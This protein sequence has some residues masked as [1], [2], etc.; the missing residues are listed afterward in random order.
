MGG[1]KKTGMVLILIG[2]LLPAVLAAFVSEY[3]P[4]MGLMWNIRNMEAV[5]YDKLTER[6]INIDGF[7]EKYP[8]YSDLS[9]EEAAGRLHK[10]FFAAM[11]LDE[12]R[13]IFLGPASPETL[14]PVINGGESGDVLGIRGDFE[15]FDSMSLL[16]QAVVSMDASRHG[17]YDITRKKIAV[18]YRY[19]L[20]PGAFLIS[21]GMLAIA[22][23][24]AEK[25]S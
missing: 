20:I 14:K 19:C 21:A 1:I 18:P 22:F 11:S 16:E 7:R 13:G 4:S 2:V 5:F 23:S 9:D 10:K 25:A 17:L 15:G 3:T 8:M 12:Y 6:Y 24:K